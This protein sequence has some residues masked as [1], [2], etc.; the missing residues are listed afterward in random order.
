[1]EAN[2][3][4][5]DK[6]SDIRSIVAPAIFQH[7]NN[8]LPE[9]NDPHLMQCLSI[10]NS[11]L[12]QILLII[13]SNQQ[14]SASPSLRCNNIG[15]GGLSFLSHV[16]Y[17]TGDTLEIKLYLNRASPLATHLYGKVV[18]S[19]ATSNGFL[20]SIEFCDIDESTREDIIRFVF[21]CERHL[22]RTKAGGNP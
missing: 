21:E 16:P 1:M 6:K 5:D 3:V 12:D 17:K 19:I 8:N 18:N 11:K 2:L 9:I 14:E 15:G 4:S 13:S 7:L 22:I 20:I 10:L